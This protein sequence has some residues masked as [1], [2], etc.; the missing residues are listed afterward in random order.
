[1]YSVPQFDDV[2][3]YIYSAVSGGAAAMIWT[4]VCKGDAETLTG[5]A[6]VPV[7]TSSAETIAREPGSAMAPLDAPMTIAAT[8]IFRRRLINILFEVA[9]WRR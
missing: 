4:S 6:R 8:K 7:V 2:I 3:E 1:M 9:F 5:T